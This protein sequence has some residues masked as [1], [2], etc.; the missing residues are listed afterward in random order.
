MVLPAECNFD[1]NFGFFA[2]IGNW[3]RHGHFITNRWVGPRHQRCWDSFFPGLS[4]EQFVPMLCSECLTVIN[5]LACDRRSLTASPEVLAVRKCWSKQGGTRA[6]KNRHSPP[7]EIFK[8]KRKKLRCQEGNARTQT[9][10]LKRGKVFTVTVGTQN[11]LRKVQNSAARGL[12][13]LGRYSYKFFLFVL[14]N[15][16]IFNVRKS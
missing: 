15:R 5:R 9:H 3:C 1:F 2:F 13:Y 8:L 12:C 11:Q 4:L 14:L 6:R 7:P 10:Q 16:K